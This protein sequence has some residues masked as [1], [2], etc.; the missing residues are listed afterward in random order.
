MLVVKFINILKVHLKMKFQRAASFSI[1]QADRPILDVS[2]LMDQVSQIALDYS[3][4][5]HGVSHIIEQD[6]HTGDEYTR[7]AVFWK[8]CASKYLFF[9]PYFFS[10]TSHF[11]WFSFFSHFPW[12]P[13]SLSC[14][15]GFPQFVYSPERIDQC[16]SFFSQL[17]WFRL[18][19]NTA[20]GE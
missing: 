12:F 5:Q 7:D 1:T 3:A 15:P 20:G 6:I 2:F 18:N 16:K 10:Q 13:E 8:M 4:T 9:I 11:P 19:V 17:T 14:I